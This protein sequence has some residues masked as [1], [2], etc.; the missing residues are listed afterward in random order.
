MS[1]NCFLEQKATLEL[2]SNVANFCAECYVDI[3]ENSVVF[4]DMQNYRY[5]CEACQEKHKATIDA[6]SEASHTNIPLFK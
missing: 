2:I 1:G 5:L 4:Y 3:R 6:N